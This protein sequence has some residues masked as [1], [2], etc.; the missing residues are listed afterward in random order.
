MFFFT[1][2]CDNFFQID[3]LDSNLRVVSPRNACIKLIFKKWDFGYTFR[4]AKQNLIELQLAQ[5]TDEI[6]ESVLVL[7][8]PSS[9]F[10]AW[11]IVFCQ[12]FSRFKVGAPIF[13][14]IFFPECSSNI[15]QQ[16]QQQDPFASHWPSKRNYLSLIQL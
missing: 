16:Q 8:Q 7:L 6:F 5:Y 12:S 10:H 2:S 1:S 15:K 9:F 13:L 11:R 14:K 4:S 3:S